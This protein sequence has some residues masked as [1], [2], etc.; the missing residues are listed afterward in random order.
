[1]LARAR[2]TSPKASGTGCLCHTPCIYSTEPI[3]RPSYKGPPIGHVAQALST[4]NLAVTE[5]AERRQ[6]QGWRPRD[7]DRQSGKEPADVALLLLRPAAVGLVGSLFSSEGSRPPV[8]AW[9]I[10]S[11]GRQG[12]S[13]RTSI[14]SKTNRWPTA[15]RATN[16][17]WPRLADRGN[18]H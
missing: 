2:T 10:S 8:F 3:P 1:M 14:S 15:Y 16:I 13:P 18:C 11:I 17:R 9:L 6:M 5:G 12:S 4:T 7:N